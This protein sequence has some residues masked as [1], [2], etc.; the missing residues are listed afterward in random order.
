VTERLTI[1]STVEDLTRCSDEALVADIDSVARE[2][3][4]AYILQLRR[5]LKQAEFCKY[6]IDF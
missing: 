1:F 5:E 2:V 3:I 6:T 4:I